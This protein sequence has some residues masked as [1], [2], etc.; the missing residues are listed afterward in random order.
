MNN[1]IKKF[2]SKTGFFLFITLISLVGI[3][4][5]LSKEGMQG[6]TNYYTN[7]EG[8]QIPNTI[9]RKC[10]NNP[11]GE[12]ICEED[13]KPKPD[14][15]KTNSKDRSFIPPQNKSDVETNSESSS[16]TEPVAANCPSLILLK[17]PVYIDSSAIPKK[18]KISS[19]PAL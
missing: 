12:R 5:M 11:N 6:E 4:F 15:L 9:Y 17:G 19:T 1:L 13:T 14:E 2:T 10:R 3:Y 16:S 8:V 7:S 18:Y